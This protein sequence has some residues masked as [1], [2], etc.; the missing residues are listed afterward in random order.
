M[1][2]QIAPKKYDRWK[3][4]GMRTYD[5]K[6][7]V[8]YD[9][10]IFWKIFSADKF[11]AAAMEQL[12]AKLD[13]LRILD[14]GCATGRLL[15][16]LIKA[17]AKNV[18]GTDIAPSIVDTAR[19]RLDGY[20]VQLDLKAADA[21]EKLP[22]PDESYDIVT[23]TGVLHHF[24]NPGKALE[25]IYR[26]SKPGSRLIILE[27]RFITPLRQFLNV[28]LYFFPSF[29]DCH[30]YTQKSVIKLLGR[31]G[32]SKFYSRN[33]TWNFFLVTAKKQTR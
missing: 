30:Y 22:W 13:N 23:L 32:Y 15:E 3:R 24:P 6:W 10:C 2:D 8:N 16:S 9:S 27:P 7:A 11:D 12:P 20:D 28:F 26:V 4:S 5:R 25:E 21:E 18:A 17:G 14:V 31:Y 19:K 33:V 1:P 29:G